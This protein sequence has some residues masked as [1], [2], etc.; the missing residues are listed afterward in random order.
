MKVALVYDR[1]NKYGGAERVLTALHE[2][3]PNAPLYT[4]V[5]NPKKATWAGVF[6]VRTS[7]LNS[8]PLASQNHELLAMLTPLAFELFNFD[9]YDLV[10]SVTSSEAKS[11]ITKPGT[12]HVCYCLTPTR[13]LWS[14][15]NS[16]IQ[17]SGSGLFHGFAPR[18][19]KM[20]VKFLRKWDYYGAQRPDYYLAISNLVKKRIEKYYGRKSNQVIYPPV[21]TSLFTENLQ[22]SRFQKEDYYLT[23]SRFV[24]YKRLD[25]VIDVFNLLG[26]K[27][28]IIG[29]GRDENI[30]KSKAKSNIHFISN[31][32]TDTE[33]VDYYIKCRAFIFA[34][35]EDF[36][37][38]AIE[39]QA[40]GKPV[41]TF[42]ESGMAETIIEGVTGE[43]FDVQSVES[44][45]EVLLTANNRIYDPIACRKNAIKFDISVF[46]KKISEFIGS[47]NINEK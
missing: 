8:I 2:I 42:R 3:W 41:F 18:I 20:S 19:L 12:T 27:L 14:G 47:I 5:Y 25:L 35:V 39:A 1:V 37:L 43:L 15:Y 30:L 26:W 22:F 10:I 45:K 9:E 38:V 11:I 7:F 33:L 13:Y 34:G 46:K 21:D 17:T 31:Y 40:C 24:G 36:G 4:T 23:V 16:Y 44:I 6:D 29:S 32:L 28:V